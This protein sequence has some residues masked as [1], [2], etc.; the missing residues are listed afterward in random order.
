MKETSRAPKTVRLTAGKPRVP[1][2][3]PADYSEAI[4]ET[5]FQ[6]IDERCDQSVLSGGKTLQRFDW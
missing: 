1:E 6:L 3:H 5:A 2:P 4:P